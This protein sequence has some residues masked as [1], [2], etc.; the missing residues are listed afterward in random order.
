MRLVVVDVLAVLEAEAAAAGQQDGQVAVG[1]AV[2]VAHAAAEEDHRAVEQRFAAVL[3]GA[4]L[5]EEVGELLHD[6]GVALGQPLEHHAGRRCDAT[7][8]A[9]P[10]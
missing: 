8:C 9:A 3:H 7:D 10:A 2:A 4:Q 5:V 1:V 6:E